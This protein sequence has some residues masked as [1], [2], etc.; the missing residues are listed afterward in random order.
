MRSCRDY[1][2]NYANKHTG[3]PY[4][5]NAE[6]IFQILDGHIKRAERN[7]E[8][9][10]GLTQQVNDQEKVIQNLRSQIETLEEIHRRAEER[11]RQLLEAE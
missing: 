7:Q 11:R 9:I 5:E 4:R 2:Q 3:G 10:N 1:F 6:K 8:R